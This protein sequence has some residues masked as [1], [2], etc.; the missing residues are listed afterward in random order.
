MGEVRNAIEQR[1]PETDEP[2]LM[3]QLT[4]LAD[5]TSRLCRVKEHDIEV[6]GDDEAPRNREKAAKLRA[7]HTLLIAAVRLLEDY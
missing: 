5:E 6:E 3:E 1:D 2:G 7:C 4:K